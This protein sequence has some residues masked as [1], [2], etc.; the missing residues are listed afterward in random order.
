MK[1]N[2]QYNAFKEMPLASHLRELKW[3]LFLCICFFAAVILMAVLNTD[4]LFRIVA[5]PILRSSGTSHL[6]TTSVT[7]GFDITL[8]LILSSAVFLSFPFWLWQLYLFIRAGLEPNE[9]HLVRA[10]F[11]LS[12]LL[13]YAGTLFLVYLAFPPLLQF[14]IGFNADFA[15]HALQFLPKMSEY[16][17]L[18][19]NLGIMFG[20]A[21][22]L[23]IVVIIMVR[24]GLV[25]IETLAQKRKYAIVLIFIIAAI[26]TPPDVISQIMLALPLLILYELSIMLSKTLKN[27]NARYQINTQ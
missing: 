27:D 12:P 3:R 21:F 25:S 2:K 18:L 19:L 14:F 24:L 4:I 7:E 1:K 17:N 23:P 22:Q 6:I 8:N 15:A 5:G 16:L 20:F 13:F 11:L 9:K 10:C 26:L